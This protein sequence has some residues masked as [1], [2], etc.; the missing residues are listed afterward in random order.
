M[1]EYKV[2]LVRVDPKAGNMANMSVIVRAPNDVMAKRTAESQWM[3]YRA[4]GAGRVL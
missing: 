1:K 2:N 3:G 4:T